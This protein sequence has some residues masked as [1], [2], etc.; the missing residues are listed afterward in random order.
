ML[1]VFW[2]LLLALVVLV[3]A[4]LLVLLGGGLLGG[5]LGGVVGAARGGRVAPGDFAEHELAT[6]RGAASGGC[7]GVGVG[8]VVALLLV[9]VTWGYLLGL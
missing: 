6:Y 5:L 9:A 8:L 7:I 3:L 4:S 2:F 1:I